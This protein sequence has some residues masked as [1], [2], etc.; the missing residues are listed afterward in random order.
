MVAGQRNTF[1]NDISDDFLDDLRDF[2][3]GL[4]GFPRHRRRK[5]RKVSHRARRKTRKHQSP[6]H[7]PRRKAKAIRRGK[8]P[9]PHHL[10]KYFFKKG[11]R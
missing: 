2:G 1:A 10:K 9:Y 11:H 7:A 8:R 4:S 5:K 3:M 6:K